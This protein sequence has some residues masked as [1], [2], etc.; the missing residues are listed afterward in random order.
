MSQL[1]SFYHIYCCVI[2]KDCIVYVQLKFSSS[3]IS[4]LPLSFVLVSV[5]QEFIPTMQ[6][7]NASRKPKC[8][9]VG[10]A[11]SNISKV[12]HT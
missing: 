9:G 7:E 10:Q 11:T 8:I 6:F 3:S 4:L 12:K 1:L 2:P 5:I